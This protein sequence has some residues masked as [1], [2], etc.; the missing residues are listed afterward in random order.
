MPGVSVA[1]LKLSGERGRV[2]GASIGGTGRGPSAASPAYSAVKE[3]TAQAL[4]AR[5]SQYVKN[6]PGYLGPVFTETARKEWKSFMME[7]GIGSTAEYVSKAELEDER[8][9]E[10]VA[11]VDR[12]RGEIDG[13]AADVKRGIDQL[14]PLRKEAR[15]KAVSGDRRGCRAIQS[16]A[17]GIFGNYKAECQTAHKLYAGCAVQGD[18]TTEYFRRAGWESARA[19]ETEL[20][21]KAHA[22]AFDLCQQ[23]ADANQNVQ[24]LHCA[25][26]ESE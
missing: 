9:R 10:E 18:A 23:V 26:P 19:A 12:I 13:L 21:E 11:K 2:G 16:S 25:R 22:E 14:T 6:D 17:A 1:Q 4:G 8:L 5:W 7:S 15:E 24:S 3:R 20:C